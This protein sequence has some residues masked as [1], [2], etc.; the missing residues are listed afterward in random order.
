MMMV[1]DWTASETL[2]LGQHKKARSKARTATTTTADATCA[3]LPRE[4]PRHSQRLV[5]RRG[6]CV[7]SLL[8]FDDRKQ[9]T[10]EV[11]FVSV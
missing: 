4:S 8:A 5:S 2:M 6:D 7:A 10:K 9:K 11:A 1:T 3:L